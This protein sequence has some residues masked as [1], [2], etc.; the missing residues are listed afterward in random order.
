MLNDALKEEIQ[1]AYTA[2]LDQQNFRPR[3]C[4]KHMIAEIA[5]TLGS[6]NEEPNKICVIEA[7]TGTGKT[8]AYALAAIPIAKHLKK[9]IVLA[10]A[11]VALQEQI[12]FQDFPSIKQY[13]GLDFSFAMAKGR[14]RY[15]CL[16]RLDLALQDSG[17][18]SKSLTLFGESTTDDD[19][20][21]IY[22]DMID[23][24]SRGK[25]DGDRDNWPDEID[26]LAWSRVSTDH[27]QCTQ[28]QCSH[29][30]DMDPT[31]GLDLGQRTD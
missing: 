29:Y 20:G 11:T 31:G 22:Q 30:D 15:L 27:A 24:L 23:Q 2:L 14:R 3:Q 18:T 19:F 9:K 28:R 5:R 16:S 1:T 13:S 6:V 17:V 8:I 21:Y 10:T 25:W 26:P 12:V 4:Q 7:G